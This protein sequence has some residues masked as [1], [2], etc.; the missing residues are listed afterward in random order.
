MSGPRAIGAEQALAIVEEVGA[1]APRASLPALIAGLE[2]VKVALMM[3]AFSPELYAVSSPDE[4]RLVGVDEA[5]ALLGI[6]KSTLYKTA[7][8]FDFVIRQNETPGRLQFSAR[9]IQRHLSH[10]RGDGGR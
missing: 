6:S 5:A 4:D 7:N 10:L 3:R 9:G 1:E 2:R 8:K